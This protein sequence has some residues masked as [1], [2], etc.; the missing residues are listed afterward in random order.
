MLPRL[1]LTEDP[2]K[3]NDFIIFR[4]QIKGKKVSGLPK[5]KVASRKLSSKKNRKH[6][7]SKTRKHKKSKSIFNLF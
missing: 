3:N 4:K 7:K 2:N 1:E 5:P 6:K